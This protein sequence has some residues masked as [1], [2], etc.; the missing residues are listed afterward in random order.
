MNPARLLIRLA[1]AGALA[2]SLAGCISL[3]PK[4]KPAQLYRFD[5]PSV[6][7]ATEPPPQ[8][9]TRIGVI[10]AGGGFDRAAG[11]DR[12]LTVSGANVAYLGQA[13]WVAPAATLFDEAIAQAFD[14][15]TGPARLAGRGEMAKVAYVL[16]VD[17]R[18]FETDYDR[19][20]KAPPVVVVRLRVAL[21]RNLDKT[22]VADRQIEAQVRAS[23]NRVGAIVE[24]YSQATA[25]VLSELVAWTN[26]NAAPVT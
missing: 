19:G 21:A 24:A 23:G 4:T 20:L 3:L 18:S 5:A 16:R 15:N 17:V 22:L 14:A 26:T 11:G 2:A 10:K 9:E 1:I 13:R 8:T 7:A 25:K 12:I 6:A